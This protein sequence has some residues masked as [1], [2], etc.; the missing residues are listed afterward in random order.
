MLSA[1]I[2][3]PD[4]TEAVL[5]NGAEGVGL[6]RTEFLYLNQPAL[7]TEEDQFEIYR[8][9]AQRLAPNPLIIRTLDLGGDKL[10]DTI[11]T[12]DELNPFLG[13]RAI[14]FCLENVEIFKSQ[15]R[16]IL[17]ASVSGNIGI[18]FPMI[19]GLD[20][21]RRGREIVRQCKEELRREG[22]PFHDELEVGIMIEV[23]TAAIMADRLAREVDFFSIGTN[24]LIQYA[25]AIDRTNERVAHLYE[26][27]HPSVV[28]LL[29]MVADAAHAHDI[30]V[31]VC[32]EM[33]GE[34]LFTP[35]LLGLGMDE[36]S[37]GPLI[38]PRVKN[39]VQRL[40][41]TECRQL[42]EEVLQLDTPAAVLERCT[43]VAQRNY[44]EL[45]S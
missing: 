8:Q 1:N 23:P 18:M 9:V 40:T 38:V 27:S 29:K 31:G 21:V 45:I 36:L 15:L 17:R 2:E 3:L 22:K 19:S 12:Q 25:V 24:D 10:T 30:W 41:I 14:R 6:Y 32:G 7:P 4:E 33:A 20:E 37:A 42:V 11:E 13:W 44:P 43:A 5:S 26:P 28:R 39:A 16:A 34:V 35:L